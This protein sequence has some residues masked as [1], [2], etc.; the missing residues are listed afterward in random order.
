MKHQQGLHYLS[1]LLSGSH[2]IM[3]LHLSENMS[4]HLPKL[5]KHT[6]IANTNSIYPSAYVKTH[7]QREK[8]IYLI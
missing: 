3:E 1:S 8:K 5:N 7:H 6:Q 2:E 4:Y